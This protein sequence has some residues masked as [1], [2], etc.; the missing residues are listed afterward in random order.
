MTEIESLRKTVTRLEEA[1]A[2]AESALERIAGDDWIV[3][4]EMPSFLD[5]YVAEVNAMSELAS[6]ALALIRERQRP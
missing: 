2:K 3:E 6:Q 4:K 1:L 5:D